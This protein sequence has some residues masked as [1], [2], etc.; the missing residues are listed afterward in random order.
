MKNLNEVVRRKRRPLTIWD[1][2]YILQ[3]KEQG[4]GV[5]EISRRLGRNH[6]VVSRFIKSIPYSPYVASLSALE[7]AREMERRAKIS[8]SS[9][10]RKQRLKSHQI[11]CYVEEKLKLGWTPELIAGRLPLEHPGC[12]TNYESV[13]QWIYRERRDL[14]QYLVVRGKGKRRKRTAKY[15]SYKQPAAPKQSIEERPQI[16]ATRKRFGDWEGDTL[17]SKQSTVSVFNLVERTSRYLVLEKIPDCS[18]QSGAEAMIGVLSNVPPRLRQSITLD[19]GPENS[20]HRHVDQTLGTESYFCHPYCAS[21]R[22]TVENRNGFLRR[23]LPKKTDFAT[24]SEHTLQ[25]IQDIHNHRPMKCLGFRTPHEVF[26][27]AFR[28]ACHA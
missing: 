26:W 2:Q 17:V 3:M 4:F 12:S 7:Q 13:Y 5:R 16:V 1:R 14:L 15:R 10:R 8:R 22:G 25:Q 21:E 18:A 19:N 6:S 9:P 23:Y 20:A 11:R 27:K 28:D 24:I